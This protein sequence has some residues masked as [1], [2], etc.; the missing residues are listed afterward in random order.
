MAVRDESIV[1]RT[2]PGRIAAV[3]RAAVARVAVAQPAVERAPG[4]SARS[5]PRPVWRGTPADVPLSAQGVVRTFR[6]RQPRY[7]AGS[8]ALY[9]PAPH[10]T[11]TTHAHPHLSAVSS[12]PSLPD[13]ALHHPR[14]GGRRF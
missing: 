5:L 9:K 2:V 6:A 12:W 13:T 3:G 7:L 8:H 10:G 14:P 11:V 1:E 4:R